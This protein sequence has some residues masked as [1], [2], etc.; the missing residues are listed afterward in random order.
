MSKSKKVT[1]SKKQLIETGEELEAAGAM[2]EVAGVVAVA[3]GAEKLEVAQSCRRDRRVTG[4]RRV[5]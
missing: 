1:V 4:R 2:A 3:E 5:Q